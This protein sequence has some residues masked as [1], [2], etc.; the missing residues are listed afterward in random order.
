MFLSGRRCGVRGLGRALGAAAISLAV[1]SGAQ[2]QVPSDPLV[3]EQ[4]AASPELLLDLPGAWELSRGEGSIVAI[5]DTGTR[6]DHPDLAPNIWVNFGEIPGNGIDDDGNGYVDDVHGIDLTTPGDV[7][8]LTDEN[9]HGTHVAGI[10]AAAAD[11]RGVVG[12]APKARIMTIKALGANG[13]GSM[14]AVAEGIRYASRSGASIVNLSLGGDQPDPRVQEAIAEAAAANVLIVASAGNVGRDG[15]AGPSYPVSVPSSNLVGVAATSPADGRLLAGFSNY[16]RLTVPLAA[17]GEMVIS[18]GH[19]GGYT[20][21]SGTSM[22]A[23][24]VAGVAAL[25]VAV[26]RDIPVADLRAALLQNAVSASLPVGSGYLHARGSVLAAAGNSSL[27]LGQRPR[28]RILRAERSASGARAVTR[29]QVA[30]SGSRHAIR[31]YRVRIG[32]RQV[33]LVRNRRTPF[34]VTVR[35]RSGAML[36]V[37]AQNA[38]RQVLARAS[39]RIVPARRGKRDIRSGGP[40]GTGGAMVWIQ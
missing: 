33:A 26:R 8:D 30:V 40:V 29:A 12:V 38:Q 35:G 25:M 11:G 18:T 23:P 2:A 7:Q 20:H 6:L 27:L 24:H 1:A 39:R 5:I 31:H 32:A 34:T 9:G 17:P 13:R 21:R 22:A 14:S 16:G 3:R 10:I 19:D 28:I 15:A 37:E 4:W 36:H